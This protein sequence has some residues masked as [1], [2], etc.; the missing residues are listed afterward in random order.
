ML[1]LIRAEVDKKHECP[2]MFGRFDRSDF[3]SWGGKKKKFFCTLHCYFLAKK[4]K[5]RL[6][7]SFR[8][9]K[10]IQSLLSCSV[11]TP[12]VMMTAIV[13][14][15]TAVLSRSGASDPSPV[16]AIPAVDARVTGV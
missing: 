2:V 1:S 16:V 15:S 6:N 10:I 13:P 12:V 11:R 5:N 3:A 4:K 9:L 14:N 7:L 8:F